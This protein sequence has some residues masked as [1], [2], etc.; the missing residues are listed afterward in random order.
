MPRAPK[1]K[2]DPA[3]DVPGA[4]VPE[5]LLRAH[6]VPLPDP[7]V[8]HHQVIADLE[9]AIATGHGSTR[10]KDVMERA[11]RAM[12]ELCGLAADDPLVIHRTPIYPPTQ[13]DPPIGHSLPGPQGRK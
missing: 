3:A 11:A 10:D 2:N 5:S 6:D 13:N 4:P 9:K 8:T 12:R 1:P 7:T